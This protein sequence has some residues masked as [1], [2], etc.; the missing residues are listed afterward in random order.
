MNSS[1]HVSKGAAALALLI[2]IAADGAQLFL[3]TPLALLLGV[4]AEVVDAAIDA[5]AAILIASLLGFDVVLLPTFVIELVP[6][7]D[8]IPTWTAC[9]LY[10]VWKRRKLTPSRP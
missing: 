3:N 7:V 6:L 10:L 8:D 1:R 2:A 5:V 9:V 4:G